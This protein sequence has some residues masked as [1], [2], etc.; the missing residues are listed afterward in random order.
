[1]DPNG[2][3]LECTQETYNAFPFAKSY[4][5]CTNVLIVKIDTA[6]DDE[7]TY[8]TYIL[9]IGQALYFGDEVEATLLC[10]NQI[11]SNVVIV[12]DAPVRLP[13]SHPSP[14]S[15]IFHE[16]DISIPLWLNGCFSELHTRTPIQHEIE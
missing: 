2:I 4:E 1:V 11:R 16:G 15:F 6:Y 10:P 12:D 8:I 9:I 5:H 14:H 3:V 7:K 13:H